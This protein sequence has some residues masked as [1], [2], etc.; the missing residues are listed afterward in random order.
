MPC[1]CQQAQVSPKPTPA[2]SPAH[3]PPI[4][5][6]PPVSTLSQLQAL[7]AWASMSNSNH[8]LVGT[9]LPFMLPIHRM[10]PLATSYSQAVEPALPGHQGHMLGPQCRPF[11]SSLT[12]CCSNTWASGCPSRDQEHTNFCLIL[13]AQVVPPYLD[14]STTLTCIGSGPA[15]IL[16]FRDPLGCSPTG[17]SP[18]SVPFIQLGQNLKGDSEPPGESLSSG[19]AE[20]ATLSVLSQGQVYECV[21]VWGRYLSKCQQGSGPRNLDL[22]GTMT[23]TG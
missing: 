1:M 3:T 22:A 10:C 5:P 12:S 8:L 23:S 16:F 19:R 6:A 18:S 21:C 9:T 14:S 15:G 11:L 7:P 17:L 13:S 4:S 2:L 20:A